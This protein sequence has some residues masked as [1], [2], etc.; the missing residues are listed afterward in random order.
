MPE[1]MV[2]NSRTRRREKVQS[3]S[4]FGSSQDRLRP[5]KDDALTAS[6]GGYYCGTCFTNVEIVWGVAEVRIGHD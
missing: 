4:L 1:I 2:L 6:G 5:F 3:S